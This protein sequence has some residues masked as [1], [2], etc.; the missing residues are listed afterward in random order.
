MPETR[1]KRIAWALSFSQDEKIADSLDEFSKK[2]T[3]L[4]QEYGTNPTCCYNKNAY[5]FLIAEKRNKKGK[6]KPLLAWVSDSI[7]DEDLDELI[8]IYTKYRKLYY[9]AEF[10]KVL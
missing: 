8:S 6:K 5:A 3:D 7:S 9:P 4:I 1:G 2:F 10:I